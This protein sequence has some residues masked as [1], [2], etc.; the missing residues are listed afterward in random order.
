MYQLSKKGRQRGR[1]DPRGT[2]LVFMGLL[3][4]GLTVKQHRGRRPHH[5]ERDC[6]QS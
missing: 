4:V 6:R 3:K 1:E 2:L 5:G